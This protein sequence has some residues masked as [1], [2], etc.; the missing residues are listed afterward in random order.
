MTDSSFK[1]SYNVI[2]SKLADLRELFNKNNNPRQTQYRHVLRPGPGPWNRTPSHQTMHRRLC[3]P[4]HK[5]AADLG[6]AVYRSWQFPDKADHKKRTKLSKL[7]Y[8]A[9]SPQMP[10]ETTSS[11]F[12]KLTLEDHSCNVFS[13]LLT[14]DSKPNQASIPLAL[15]N[16]PNNSCGRRNHMSPIYAWFPCLSQ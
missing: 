15:D 13:R 5:R 14:A 12:A 1:D 9:L 2:F 4:V 16:F 11:W 8:G 6:K 3:R 10:I 7:L